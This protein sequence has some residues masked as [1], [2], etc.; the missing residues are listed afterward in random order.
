MPKASIYFTLG[1]IDDKHD[2]KAIKRELDTLP[3][4]ISVSVN[5]S[6]HRVTVDFDTSRVKSGRIVKQVETMGYPIMD[7]KI[8]NHIL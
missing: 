3:G 8:D 1:K 2:S 7:S 4:V 5:D 6:S